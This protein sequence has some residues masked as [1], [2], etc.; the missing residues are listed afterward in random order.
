MIRDQIAIL[1]ARTVDIP[2]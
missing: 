2:N 1:I